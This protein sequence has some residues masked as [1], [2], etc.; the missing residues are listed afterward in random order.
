MRKVCIWCLLVWMV[1]ITASEQCAAQKRVWEKKSYRKGIADFFT[2]YLSGVKGEFEKAVWVEREDVGSVRAMVWEAW[3]E[4]NGALQEEKLVGLRGLDEKGLEAGRWRLPAELEPDAVMPYYWGSKG[5]M[6]EGGYPLFLYTHGS[7]H[8][9]AEWRTGL[10]ICRRFEDAPSVY[11]IPQIPNMGEYYRWWQ[12]SKQYAWEK[13][14]RQAF[15]SGEVNPNRV[16]VFGISEGGYGSQRLASFYADYWAAAGPMAGGEP[17][18]NA[19][20]ENCRNMAFLLRTGEADRGFYRNYLTQHVKEVFD[21]LERANPGSF[22]HRV[23][24]IPGFG[25]AIDYTP[26]TPWLRRH[27]RNPYPKRVSW[28]NFE[29][30]GRYRD[31]F[32]NLAVKVRSNEGTDERT[33]YEWSIEDNH[34]DLKA[35]VVKYKAVEVDPRWGIELKFARSYRPATTGRVVIYLCDE[36][37]DLSREVTVSVNGREVFRGMVRPSVKD[38]VNS[39]ALFFD[40]ARIYPA[41]VEVDLS[42]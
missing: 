34:V 31:G 19:P 26:T 37:V 16:Y 9:D 7:G 4:A 6:P 21:S 11:F 5:E 14:L 12:R 10:T 30:D 35:Q 25:H 17:M 2:D 13:L 18:K 27:V 29:M 23:E 41:S 32:Y 33:Y 24:L 15:V 39:C 8:K 20:A 28:E 1:G 36:L 22:V 40:P 3:R 38:M 42:K